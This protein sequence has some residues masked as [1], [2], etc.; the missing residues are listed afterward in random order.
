[1][2]DAEDLS[3]YATDVPAWALELAEKAWPGALTLVVRAN[4]EVPAEFRRADGTVALRVP[5][6]TLVRALAREVGPLAVTSA[7]THGMPAPATSDD[8]ERRIADAADLTLA[9][10]PT[11][12]GE[13]STIVDATGAEP[14]VI[15]QGAIQL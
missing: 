5:D 7:N 6:S 4:E 1:M 2:A 14:K 3:R 15:R 10:G 8:I 12:A 13:A 9:A 11:P